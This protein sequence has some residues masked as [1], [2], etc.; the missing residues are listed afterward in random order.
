MLELK[1]ERKTVKENKGTKEK[2]SYRQI[3]LQTDRT[4]ERES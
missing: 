3:E 2:E 1:T 4:T